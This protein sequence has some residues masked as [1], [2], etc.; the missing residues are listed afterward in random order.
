MKKMIVAAAAVVALTGSAAL[1][2]VPTLGNFQLKQT[3]V[4]TGQG[5]GT[6]QG[7]SVTTNFGGNGGSG[8]SST[9]FGGGVGGGGT[10]AG[11]SA[12]LAAAGGGGASNAH[13][14]GGSNFIGTTV[15]GGQ[16]QGTATGTGAACTA[17]NGTCP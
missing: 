10:L 1:A 17:F 14:G 7:S 5:Q 4:S 3:G 2:Q 13:S 11:S 9:Q 12:S 16:G 15:A 8:G 6:F